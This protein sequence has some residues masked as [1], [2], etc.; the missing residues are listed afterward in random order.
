MAARRPNYAS[1]P[2]VEGVLSAL[3]FNRGA[4]GTATGLH[5]PAAYAAQM[6]AGALQA[7]GSP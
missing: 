7:T 2:E 6:L 4:T 1:D 5:A 3:A